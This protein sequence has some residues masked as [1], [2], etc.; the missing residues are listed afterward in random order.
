[1]TGKKKRTPEEI[2]VE[3]RENEKQ[4]RQFVQ[5][6]RRAIELAQ[7]EY[8]QTVLSAN[9]KIST[10]KKD[11]IE[12]AGR[13]LESLKPLNKISTTLRK[14]FKGVIEPSWV[15]AVCR[16][17]ERGW[18]VKHKK[19]KSGAGRPSKDFEKIST[20]FLTEP[21]KK[22]VEAVET[23]IK[24]DAA[25]DSLIQYLTG[26]TVADQGRVNQETPKGFNW[27]NRLVE[28][29]KEH[30]FTLAKQMTDSH[31]AMT[32]NQLRTVKYVANAFIDVLYEERE[33]RKKKAAM[34]GV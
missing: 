13:L 25:L 7:Q 19:H 4:Y 5:E 23:E 21:E 3:I 18:I 17:L 24:R 9:D 6:R 33:L 14:D 16:S 12:R 26:K 10:L 15:S 22:F 27:L 20:N 31:I 1:V 28:Q 8:H 34:E 32:M 2:A 30:M 29:S 11:T